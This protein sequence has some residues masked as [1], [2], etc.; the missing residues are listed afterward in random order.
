MYFS[1]NVNE[2]LVSVIIDGSQEEVAKIDTSRLTD[3]V[4]S[5]DFVP[6]DLDVSLSIRSV[7]YNEFNFPAKGE[8][9]GG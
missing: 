7:T 9:V 2:L 1:V 3:S 5:L 8:S 6:S 4:R